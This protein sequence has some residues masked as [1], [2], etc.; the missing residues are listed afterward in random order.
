M[1]RSIL[2]DKLLVAAY[3]ASAAFVI[4]GDT[5]HGLIGFFEKSAGARGTEKLKGT[6][7]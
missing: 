6:Q 1:V 5:I 4:K 3:T 7:L 2:K